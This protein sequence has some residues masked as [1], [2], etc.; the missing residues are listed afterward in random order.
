MDKKFNAIPSRNSFPLPSLPISILSNPLS[1]QVEICRFGCPD[2]CQN[3]GNYVAREQ[4]VTSS[5]NSY[6]GP[7]PI[8]QQPAGVPK[9]TI[10]SQPRPPPTYNN[11]SPAQNAYNAGFFRTNRRKD[12][13]K[14]PRKQ[15]KG[16][17]NPANVPARR[18]LPP[19]GRP[20]GQIRLVPTPQKLVADPPSENAR[21]GGQYS[22]PQPPVT[23]QK[24]QRAATA[25]RERYQQYNGPPQPAP[26]QHQRRQPPPPP[27]GG[28]R[29]PTPNR[30]I[31]E[32]GN[33]VAEEGGV[34]G[35]L[36]GGFKLPS[37]PTLPK[38]SIPFFGSGEEEESEDRED[39]DEAESGVKSEAIT[40]PLG[41]IPPADALEPQV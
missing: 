22:P 14:T 30:R 31:D 8:P 2:H 3:P 6:S 23:R 35:N 29:R 13:L 21:S 5:L 36:L 9:V 17:K 20:Q 1:F 28:Q 39:A 37:L 24:A 7:P 26:V 4:E 40:I 33:E 15:S 34:F 27:A 25:P 41:R 19:Q 38:I 18:P 32:N 16:I 10:Q 12:D 11:Q